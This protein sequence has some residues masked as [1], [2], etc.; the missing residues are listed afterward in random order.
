MPT[1]T[2]G[3]NSYISYEEAMA[4]LDAQLGA[5]RWLAASVADQQ[6]ALIL[7]WRRLESIQRW[8]GRKTAP[9]QAMQWPRD[10]IVLEGRVL[11]P[12]EI[13]SAIG[14]AQALEAFAILQGFL[15]AT[16]PEGSVQADPNTTLRQSLQAQGVTAVSMAGIS[17]TYGSRP[18]YAG[19][20][21]SSDAHALLKRYLRG[22]GT[23]ME[24]PPPLYPED[25]DVWL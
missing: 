24:S 4:F 6:R 8:Q 12:R 13:P 23:I 15:P 5:D 18:V 3:V 25:N 11:N 14:Q 22:G 7:S 10:G 17:E 19:V 20:L 21:E 1:L 16:S 2:V 9:G